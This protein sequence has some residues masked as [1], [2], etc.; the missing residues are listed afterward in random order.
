M[1]V[2]VGVT[3]TCIDAHPQWVESVATVGEYPVDRARGIEGFY[4]LRDGR[5]TLHASVRFVIQVA[6]VGT[7]TTV[8]DDTIF[9]EEGWRPLSVDLTPWVDQSVTLRFVTDPNGHS[10]EDWLFGG[11]THRDGPNGRHRTTR[12]PT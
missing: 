12:P 6:R 1:R 3:R 9:N 8:F 11:C 10:W 2:S 7:H 4:D 5:S